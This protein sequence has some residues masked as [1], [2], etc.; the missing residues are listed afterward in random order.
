MHGQWTQHV[1]VESADYCNFDDFENVN[2]VRNLT[3][4]VL[5]TPYTTIITMTLLTNSPSSPGFPIDVRKWRVPTWQVDIPLQMVSSGSTNRSQFDEYD[6]LLIA[7]TRFSFR[8]VPEWISAE[9]AFTVP[10]ATEDNRRILRTCSYH[11][12]PVCSMA[13]CSYFPSS[14]S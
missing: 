11:C 6:C 14:Q 1:L 7:N 12:S 13:R 3:I 5:S 9:I 2:C 8:K 10:I 4:R